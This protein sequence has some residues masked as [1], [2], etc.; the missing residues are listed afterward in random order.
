MPANVKVSMGCRFDVEGCVL[1]DVLAEV[2]G[3][4]QRV[5]L[6]FYLPSPLRSAG[7]G[8]IERLESL[9]SSRTRKKRSR[10]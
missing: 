1:G 5:S 2:A 8:T 10:C 4:R 6:N 7:E 9:I 3:R